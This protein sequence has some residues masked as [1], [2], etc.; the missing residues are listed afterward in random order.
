MMQDEAFLLFPSCI[1]HLR[2][3]F[4]SVLHEPAHVRPSGVG[5]G[6]IGHRRFAKGYKRRRHAGGE[7][8][9]P[10]S[11]ALEAALF[12]VCIMSETCTSD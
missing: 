8:S 3:T 12:C 1:I 4:S 11:G 10:V 6:S 9:C 7:L 5:L 2:L